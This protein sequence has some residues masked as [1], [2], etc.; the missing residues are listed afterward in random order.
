MAGNSQWPASS[1]ARCPLVEGSVWPGVF[2]ALAAE[3]FCRLCGPHVAVVVPEPVAS[4][5]VFGLTRAAA[6][7]ETAG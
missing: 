7:P 1:D 2:G 4:D 5:E 3:A 6:W